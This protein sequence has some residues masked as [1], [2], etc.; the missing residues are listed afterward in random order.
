MGLFKKANRNLSRAIKS[1]RPRPKPRPKP[2]PKRKKNRPLHAL[3]KVPPLK[4]KPV[5][6]G[7]LNPALKV[8]QAFEDVGEKVVDTAKDVGKNIGKGTM[9]V[10]ETTGEF[11]GDT[12]HFLKTGDFGRAVEKL[13][14]EETDA[15]AKMYDARAGY[16]AALGAY[17]RTALK[18]RSLSIVHER[19]F[20]KGRRGQHGHGG[21]EVVLTT[22]RIFEVNPDLYGSPRT[23][24]MDSIGLKAVGDFGR[25]V[26]KIVPLRLP[27]SLIAQ[28]SELSEARKLLRANIKSFRRATANINRATADLIEQ[29]EVLRD[30]VDR[31]EADFLARAVDLETGATL[32]LAD[33]A[34]QEASLE[35][36][37]AL[38]AA[39]LTPE[40]VAKATEMA[41]ADVEGLADA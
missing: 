9:A 23:R 33:Q 39:G 6:K 30:E 35:M 3:L 18:L 19:S 12:E 29:T 27:H 24:F 22:G 2:K 20:S 32:D 31:I 7:P 16:D 10:V 17:V 15:E 40:D 4:R 41:L 25:N 28:Q 1:V 11:I 13:Q 14:A 8:K 37:R 26:Q 34:A 5:L 38:L 21:A 36:A